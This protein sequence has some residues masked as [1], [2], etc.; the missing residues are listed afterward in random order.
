MIQAVQSAHGVRRAQPKRMRILFFLYKN[1]CFYRIVAAE[2]P[3]GAIKLVPNSILDHSTSPGQFTAQSLLLDFMQLV[4][5]KLQHV[6]LHEPL[7][8]REYF[9]SKIL[10]YLRKNY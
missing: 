2:L 9:L 4:E 8:S 10:L 3:W 6:E 5:R 7:V 1:I